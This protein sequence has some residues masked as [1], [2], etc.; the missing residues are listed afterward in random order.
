MDPEFW[1]QRWRDGQ[2]GF[3]QDEPNALMV[4]HFTAAF[5]KAGDRVFVPLCGKTRDIDWLMK[6]GFRV[7]GA[8]LSALAVE[9]L[10]DDLNVEPEMTELGDLTRYRGSGIDIFVGDIFDLSAETLGSVDVIYDR[11]AFVAL[12]ED[13][14]PKYAAHLMKITEATDQFLIGFEY[15]QAALKGPPFATPS[16]EIHR[17]YGAGYTPTRIA[18]ADVVGGLKGKCPATEVVWRLHQPS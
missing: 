4:Q 2:I 8:E 18:S 5:A 11:A 12:P 15:D 9:Q 7:A 6:Q 13:L 17:C 3:H 1:Q 14:R 10:F 16:E